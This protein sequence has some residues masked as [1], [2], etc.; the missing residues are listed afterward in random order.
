MR[1]ID[2][3]LYNAVIAVADKDAVRFHMPGHGGAT[4]LMVQLGL[5]GMG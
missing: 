2:A 1:R 4:R 5:L 3:P